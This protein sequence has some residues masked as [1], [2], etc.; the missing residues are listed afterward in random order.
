MTNYVKETDQEMR[1]KSNRIFQRIVASLERNVADRYDYEPPKPDS[2]KDH[3]QAAL[4]EE[5]WDLASKLAAELA[6]GRGGATDHRFTS[7]G[8]TGILGRL[9]DTSSRIAAKLCST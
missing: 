2:L 4:N 1:Q 9:R 3:L 5:N 7:P 6:K 8:R